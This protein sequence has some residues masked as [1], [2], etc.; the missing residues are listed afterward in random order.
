[1]KGLGER[2]RKASRKFKKKGNP[3]LRSLQIGLV[4]L[5]LFFFD[6]SFLS[7][8]KSDPS[9]THKSQ[10]NQLFLEKNLDK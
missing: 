5:D 10:K 6:I 7:G 1:M 8:G 4:G 2:V 3:V 9:K